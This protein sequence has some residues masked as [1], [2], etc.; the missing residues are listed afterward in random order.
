VTPEAAVGG[1]IGLIHDGDIIEIDI[2]ERRIDLLL[3]KAELKRR[4]TFFAPKQKPLS[5]ILARY[6]KTVAQA[7]KGAVLGRD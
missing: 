7:D 3:S 5:G 4:R 2:R 6:A 1:P